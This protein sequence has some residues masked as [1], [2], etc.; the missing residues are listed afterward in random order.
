[1]NRQFSKLIENGKEIEL[2]YHKTG[3]GAEYLTDKYIECPN[4]HKEGT[5]DEANI[6]LRIDGGELEITRR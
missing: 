4:G 3:G 2:Y 1:M 6:I 5:F